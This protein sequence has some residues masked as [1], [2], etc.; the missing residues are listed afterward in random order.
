MAAT[1]WKLLAAAGI[2]AL[3]LSAIACGD[4]TTKPQDGNGDGDGD[5]G[6]GDGGDGDGKPA[7]KPLLGD[8]VAG[9]KCADKADCGEKG[10]CA[11]K[12][13]GGSL[14]GILTSLAGIDLDVSM[15]TPG[16]YCTATCKADVDCGAGSACFGLLP[17]QIPG[18]GGSGECRQACTKNED[19]RPEY[20]CAQLNTAGI[21]ALLDGLPASLPFDPSGF[22][23][24]DSIAKTCQPK[25]K[26]TPIDKDTVGKGCLA[27][28]ECGAGYCLG[29]TAATATAEA[30]KG[31]C[32]A[33]C[34]SDADCGAPEGACLGVIYGSAGTCSET[35]VQDSDC[36][37]NAEDGFVCTELLGTKTCLPPEPVTEDPDAGVEPDASTESDA[38]V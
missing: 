26:V 13:T 8:N 28:S 16:G 33:V 22:I 14:P 20:E 32:S 10:T 24:E 23:T 15:A 25:P 6:D 11:D 34:A 30:T 37:R 1:R 7:E 31:S 36:K 38:S 35:C 27:D 29:A 3:M 4:D 17:I 12:L 19:C 21:A 18:L 5:K 9:I 2:S